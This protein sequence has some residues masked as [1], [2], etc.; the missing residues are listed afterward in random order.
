MINGLEKIVSKHCDQRVDIPNEDM[1]M[2]LE[3]CKRKMEICK[4]ENKGYLC[5][6]F[7]NEIKNYLIRR[8]I[9]TKSY[10]MKLEGSKIGT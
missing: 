6:L 7:D 2:I 4:I 5:L 8:D 3:L 9:N 1:C 10:L